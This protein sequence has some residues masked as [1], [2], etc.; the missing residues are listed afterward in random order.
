MALSA[1]P[2]DSSAWQGNPESSTSDSGKQPPYNIEAE[3][4][5][6]GALLTNNHVYEHISNITEVNHFY[7]D[8]NGRIYEAIVHFIDKN[9]VADPIQLGHYFSDDEALL[10]N[11]GAQFLHDLRDGALT[12]VNTKDYAQTLRELYLKRELIELGT[13]IVD[14]AYSTDYQ[15]TA[16]HQIEHAEATLYQMAEQGNAE[17]GFLDFGQSLTKAIEIAEVAHKRDGSFGG[18]SSGL[19]DLDRL[20]G[21]LHD[22]DL[23]ILAGRPSM[24]KTALA[25]NIAFNVAQ[26]DKSVGFFSLEMSA[27]QLAMRILSEQAEVPSEKIRR[28]ELS[29]DDFTK[30]AMKARDLE[31]TKFFI[32]DTPAITISTLRTRARRLKRKQGLDMIIVDY[33][34]LMRSGTKTGNENRVQ[35]I[36]EI[37]RGLKAVAKELNIPVIALSQLSRAVEQ[38]EDKTPQLSDLRE[39]GSIEQDAD[40]VMFV[41][42]EEYYVLKAQPVRKMEEDQAKFQ[43]RHETWIQ[44][45]TEV[46]QK[47]KVIIGKQRH[48]PTGAVDLKFEGE[49]TRFSD[50]AQE[51][52]TSEK[53]F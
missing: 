13:D 47:A 27:D 23:L 36:S 8:L 4:A 6:L 40:V 11:G 48:G 35:E 38:R 42:R 3:Q 12:V 28:G 51:S 41:F 39:S 45:C 25:T 17:G 5:L 34:Q 31:K 1:I 26:S 43:S 10:N 15:H 18:I 2:E 14:D 46:H 20:M 30:V 37:S 29:N 24:G 49:K 52:H 9:Q 33:L 53:R 7:D 22:S 19:T 21:G 50:L 32:D 16:Q 44:R